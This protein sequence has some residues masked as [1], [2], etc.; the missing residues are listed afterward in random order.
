MSGKEEQEWCTVARKKK[1]HTKQTQRS[2]N[3]IKM[4]SARQRRANQKHNNSI[5]LQDKEIIDNPAEKL[6]GLVEAVQ[7]CVASLRDSLYGAYVCSQLQ[8]H[9]HNCNTTGFHSMYALGI[10]SFTSPSSRLQLAL[11]ILLCEKFA[12]RS[13]EIVSHAATVAISDGNESTVKS[14]G[15]EDAPLLFDPMMNTV[16]KLVCDSFGLRVSAV[17]RRGRYRMK[18]DGLSLIFM[19]HCPYRLYC[20][21]LW[22]NWDILNNVCIFG[23]R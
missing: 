16:D 22:E 12:L 23:N 1:Q 19:P 2:S 7:L 9:L 14:P 21:F 10:G 20:N 5:L 4:D 8:H 3:C 18:M 15:N 6:E 17:N 11:F 13:T